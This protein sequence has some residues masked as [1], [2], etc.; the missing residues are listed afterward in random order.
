MPPRPDGHRDHHGRQP[1]LSNYPVRV[2]SIEEDD[3][4]LLAVTAEE[5]VTG[6]S[7]PAYYPS[8]G[9]G[10]FAPNWAVPAV[11]VNAPLIF[12]PPL[13]ATN[14]VAQ[15]WVGA[16]GAAYGS[17]TQWGGAN[18]YVSVDDVTYSQIAVV[19]SP[20]RQG[21]L[22]AA[23]PAARRLGLGR[24]AGG[25]PRRERRRR[26][27]GTS[28]AAAQAGATASLVD[29]ELIAYETATLTGANAYNLTGLAR[30][31]SGSSPAYHSTGAPFAR[32]DGAVVKYNLPPNL[33]GQTL[34]FKFQ[35]FN[36]FGGGIEDL[37]TCAVYTFTPSGGSSDPIAAQLS[38][39]IAARSRPGYR[40]A[41]A[42]RRLRPGYGHRH[43]F[44]RSR[45]GGDVAAPDHGGDPDRGEL[46]ISASSRRPSLS[47]T[48]SAPS[49]T[50]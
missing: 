9:S 41:D 32:L 24:H 50:P 45:R 4:G 25:Q 14:G 26:L 16:S 23:L 36:V 3:K 35:S 33:A 27:A 48:T 49:V 12:E 20:L 19:T 40:R 46:E 13:A 2:I 18:V 39:G 31:F 30:A 21:F 38:S 1:G 11:P 42:C 15:V 29:C 22:T 17:S 5:L 28:Q 47:R 44:G 43:G 34:Y 6:V 10:N 7:T 37:S 8:A